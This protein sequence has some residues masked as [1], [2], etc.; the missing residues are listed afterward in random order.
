MKLW[1]IAVAAVCAGVAL[2]LLGPDACL[3]VASGR[4]EPVRD[5]L[6]PELRSFG[7]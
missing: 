2:G 5:A 1:L 4:F 7:S 3:G 6:P